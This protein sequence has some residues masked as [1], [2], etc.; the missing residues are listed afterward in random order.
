MHLKLFA[1]R[2]HTTLHPRFS[3]ILIGF[4][5]G[6]FACLL[7]DLM[8]RV[9]ID[10]PVNCVATHAGSGIW[11]MIAVAF[12]VEKDNLEGFTRA[13]G[14]FKGGSWHILGAQ[15]C[16]IV[17]TGTWGVVTTLIQLFVI[18][19]TIGIRLKLEEELLGCDLVEHG[20]GKR[21]EILESLNTVE[22]N[23]EVE[24]QEKEAVDERSCQSAEFVGE[25]VKMDYN[26]SHS[27][28]DDSQDFKELLLQ[29][30]ENTSPRQA[31]SRTN[32]ECHTVDKAVQVYL[33]KLTE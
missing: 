3:G 17:V 23:I 24:N 6:L 21:N 26:T 31:R 7:S 16:A 19:K 33:S 8:N 29:E 2:I 25:H 15:L 4:F 12:F 30:L 22:N 14:I 27:A 10:D 9:K 5:G 13:N 18:E 11:G 28:T 20:I 1:Y 32:Q